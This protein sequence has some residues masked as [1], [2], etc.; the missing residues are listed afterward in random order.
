MPI[1]VINAV[2][3]H[4]A[5]CCSITRLHLATTYRPRPPRAAL[6][7]SFTLHLVQANAQLGSRIHQHPAAVVCTAPTAC[8]AQS[9]FAP[10]TQQQSFRTTIQS[11]MASR[12]PSMNARMRADPTVPAIITGYHR[13]G[14]FLHMLA[15]ICVASVSRTA[16][17]CAALT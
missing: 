15:D 10:P 13:P 16:S 8:T 7:A 5:G 17:P 1:S 14:I 9:L 12:S 2:P 11:T 4:L 3:V 6:Q